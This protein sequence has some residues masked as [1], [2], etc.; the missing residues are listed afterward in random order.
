MVTPNV[1]VTHGKMTTITTHGKMTTITSPGKITTIR[2]HGKMT[3]ITT[4][5]KMTVTATPIMVPGQTTEMIVEKGDIRPLLTVGRSRNPGGKR[6]TSMG[7][8]IQEIIGQA[9][10]TYADA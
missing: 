7:C 9:W 3:I 1:A 10:K 4:H 5:G 8:V 2:T 6:I